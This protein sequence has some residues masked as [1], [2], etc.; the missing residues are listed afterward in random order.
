MLD[1][2]HNV[3]VGNMMRRAVSALAVLLA[4]AAY[5]QPIPIQFPDPWD[6]SRY[7]PLFLLLFLLSI[8]VLIEVARR[9]RQRGEQ[10]RSEWRTVREVARERELSDKECKLLQDFVRKYAR[11]EP[12]RAVTVYRVFDACISK[13]IELYKKSATDAEL[14]SRGILLRD[15][16]VRLGLDYVPFGQQIT[17]TRE[18]CAGQVL[19]A[20]V[21]AALSS[22]WFKMRV[23][24]VHE[25]RFL[26]EVGREDG[27]PP[28]RLGEKVRFRMWREEDARYVFTSTLV[29]IQ[30]EP[31]EWVFEHSEELKRVQARA[32]YRVRYDQ[33][34]SVAVLNAPLNDDYSDIATRV[35][36][37]MIRARITSLSGGGLALVVEEP[38]PTRIV[39]RTHLE[40]PGEPS[41]EVHA[42][43]VSTS[44]LARGRQLV[45]T[46]FVGISEETAEAITKYAFHRQQLRIAEDAEEDARP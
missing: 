31:R 41:L 38:M 15:L 23:S 3:F 28:F 16:R 7:W 14:E 42:R 9:V 8:S 45:R 30:D 4:G 37:T 36:V 34:A 24:Q 5:A 44:P 29:R 13:D 18:I 43:V 10:L 22:P 27:E 6:T 46:A 40:L 21:E 20:A 33:P 25:A 32:H 39:L 2:H 12:L 17:S 19:W 11:K 26:V 1:L 35:P